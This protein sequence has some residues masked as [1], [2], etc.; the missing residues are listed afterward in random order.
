MRSYDE[1]LQL[2]LSSVRSTIA[3]VR[4]VEPSVPYVFRTETTN[5][6]EGASFLSIAKQIHILSKPQRF[7]NPISRIRIIGR[8][9]QLRF[10]QVE[11]RPVAGGGFF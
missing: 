3:K 9:H 8:V 1:A 5:V 2:I 10:V 11:V 7:P 4:K 6:K